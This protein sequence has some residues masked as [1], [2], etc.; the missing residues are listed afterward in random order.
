MFDVDFNRLGVIII[1]DW[2]RLWCWF[3]VM[4]ECE[5][6]ILVLVFLVLLCGLLF[7]SVENV[8]KERGLLFNFWKRKNRNELG[9]CK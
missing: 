5:L 6:M 3:W 8:R 1:G 2:V 9:R 4:E 7:L